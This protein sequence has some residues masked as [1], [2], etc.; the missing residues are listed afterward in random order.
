MRV[1]RH[2]LCVTSF[3]VRDARD[4]TSRGVCSP[5]AS[6]LTNKKLKVNVKT[7]ACSLQIVEFEG[8]GRGVVATRDFKRGDFV[9]EYAGDLIDRK[10]AKSR[11]EKYKKNSKIGCYMYYFSHKNMNY[12]YVLWLE[13]ESRRCHSQVRI[14]S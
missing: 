4:V 9:V 2:F 14:R 10:T 1:A 6:G 5:C 13:K 8:K 11:E 12:W 7:L 3:P